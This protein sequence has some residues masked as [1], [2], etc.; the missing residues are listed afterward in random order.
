MSKFKKLGRDAAE[1]SVDSALSLIFFYGYPVPTSIFL[2]AIYALATQKNNDKKSIG[3]LYPSLDKYILN[4][5]AQVVPILAEKMI[6]D[7]HLSCI[8]NR[9]Q[10]IET[11]KLSIARF[12]AI[13]AQ[14]EERLYLPFG[15]DLFNLD[16]DINETILSNPS[17]VDLFPYA[18]R[19]NNLV[20]MI[21]RLKKTI[22]V[23]I[24]SVCA[25]S[26]AT[27]LSLKKRFDLNIE[28]GFFDVNA[29]KQ[30]ETILFE[31]NKKNDFIFSANPTL[32]FHSNGLMDVKEMSLIKELHYEYQYLMTKSRKKKAFNRNNTISVY[33]K[34]TAQEHYQISK[35]KKGYK[36]Q[37]IDEFN[38]YPNLENDL[39]YAWEPLAF[40]LENNGWVKIPNTE[41][42]IIFSIFGND[43][44]KDQL[45][46]Y[47]L[48]L[49]CREWFYCKQN[50]FKS[51]ELL[52]ERQ[53]FVEKFKQG[54]GIS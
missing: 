31:N 29:K 36:I 27:L 32:T 44:R 8:G 28:I 48:E 26:I 52:L 11:R 2:K 12:E 21:S 45:N 20:K 51:L 33:S 47:F 9:E 46:K 49:F 40:H 13:K 24:T 7:F 6:R 16:A 17:N 18:E 15:K 22:R 1:F 3:S 43:N 10:I 38:V 39:V 41:H 34:S 37:L 23:S 35:S 50:N 42:Q 4:K 54:S 5:D 53:D 14:S 30:M 25:A 19:S